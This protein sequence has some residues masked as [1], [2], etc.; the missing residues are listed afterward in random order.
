MQSESFIEIVENRRELSTMV[1]YYLKLYSGVDS[2]QFWF[3]ILLLIVPLVLLYLLIDRKRIFEIGFF[4][5]AI[6]SLVLYLDT[7][8]INEGIWGYP[9]QVS[10]KFA[11]NVGIDA[12]LIPIVFMLIYQYF[13][14]RPKLFYLISI[15]VTIFFP[16]VIKP[17]MVYFD[18]FWL[19]QDM[20]YTKL[21]M[22][23]LVGIGLPII[24]TS[25]FKYLKEKTK[26]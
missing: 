13:R 16:F 17:I 8:G 24:L 4:G 20:S 7:Y 2:W 26:K 1:E 5:F 23:Y 19:S 18:L 22:Y 21:W 10:G 14:H 3:N 11:S 25:F 12:A 9:Y 6:H 15:S